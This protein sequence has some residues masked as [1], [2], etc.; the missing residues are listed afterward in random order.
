[1][2]IKKIVTAF[3]LTFFASVSSLNTNVLQQIVS[4]YHESD[5][6]ALRIEV[7]GQPVLELGD[8]V[9]F[10]TMSITKSIVNLAIGILVDQGKIPSIDTPI[11]TYFPEWNVEVKRD[12]TIRHVLSHTT[13]LKSF[14]SLE[15]GYLTPDFI[16]SA[17]DAEF[18]HP[19]GAEFMYNNRAV[20]LLSGIVEKVSGKRLDIFVE[21]ALFVP[22]GI[23][24][25]Y[26]NLDFEGHALGMSG[27]E[28]TAR[29]LAL[30]GQLILN[31]GMWNGERLISEAW[32]E[33]TF[34]PSQSFNVTCGL[35]WWL[36][37]EEWGRWPEALLA[38]YEEA[39]ISQKYI[40]LLKPLS[41]SAIQ[42]S[43]DALIDIFGTLEVYEGFVAEVNEAGLEH[44][45]VEIGDIQGYRADGYL[46]QYLVIIP[47]DNVVAIRQI[48]YGKKPDD[49][50]DEF[51]DF[52]DL[53]YKL[54]SED[55][56]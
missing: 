50:Y 12:V 51:K 39:G 16:R 25:Y 31:K 4:R 42:L 29:E 20:N 45:I 34:Q 26:W 55:A 47:K 56:S 19:V 27:L 3:F 5:S 13:G 53:V 28:M 48:Q 22:L 23:S 10:E 8:E 35:L 21:E 18:T 38:R 54:H 33:Q 2:K 30:I 7:N 14:S 6:D 41:G 24:N 37:H 11:Y 36:N 52:I 49:Q 44:C 46:G 9:P 32:L 40:D 43:T 17:L 15:E 1:M